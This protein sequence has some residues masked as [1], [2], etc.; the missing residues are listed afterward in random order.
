MTYYPGYTYLLSSSGDKAEIPYCRPL[1]KNYIKAVLQD[2]HDTAHHVYILLENLPENRFAIVRYHD[3]VRQIIRPD[4]AL[5]SDSFTI[6]LFYRHFDSLHE[7]DELRVRFYTEVFYYKQGFTPYILEILY[8]HY[9]KYLCECGLRENTPVKINPKL[10]RK[11]GLTKSDS[12]TVQ[13]YIQQY[14]T[15][16]VEDIQLE[17]N[18]LTN[19]DCIKNKK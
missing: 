6:G 15:N 4:T 5:E 14:N 2:L 19:L 18:A 8:K 16:I 1:K 11:Y 3:H 12:K 13:Q 7:L 17:Y 10:I 9:L